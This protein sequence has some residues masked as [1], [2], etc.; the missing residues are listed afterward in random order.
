M[1]LLLDVDGVLQFGRPDFEDHIRSLGW[2]GSYVDFQRAL[3]RDDEYSQTLTGEADIR[4]VLKRM[5]DLFGQTIDV[6][7]LMHQWTGANL[8]F[9]E[10]LLAMLPGLNVTSIHLATNQDPVRGSSIRNFYQ[11]KAGIG[12][13][14]LSCEIGHRKPHAEYFHHI[15]GD[16]GCDSGDVVFIDDSLQNVESARALG[17][18]TVLYENNSQLL[19]W[20]D[21]LL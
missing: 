17:I 4:L 6:E 10:E 1:I 16:L 3:F 18:H 13:I 2:Q 15:L 8:T 11:G 21:D 20:L 7:A 12:D 5:L 9:N 19:A 14:Y